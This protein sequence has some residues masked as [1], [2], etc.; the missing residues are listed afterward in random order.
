MDSFRLTAEGG[1]ERFSGRIL[2]H[3][4]RVY[5]N[6]TPGV[7]R[8]AGYKPLLR[9]P[10]PSDAGQTDGEGFPIVY[11]S[12]YTDEGDAIRLSYERRVIRDAED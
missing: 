10:L 9:D 3:N 8:E 7:L 4:G 5:V 12:V 2:R 6:P 11:A 1:A